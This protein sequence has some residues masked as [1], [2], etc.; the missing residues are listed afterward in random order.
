L[1]FPAVEP[2]AVW[3]TEARLRRPAVI[4]IVRNLFPKVM[5]LDFLHSNKGI[6]LGVAT[7]ACF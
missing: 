3:A 7:V 4:T 6:E 2:L 1:V 5:L